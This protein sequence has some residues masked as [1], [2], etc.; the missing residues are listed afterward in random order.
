[1]AKGDLIDRA[2]QVVCPRC[3]AKP[4]KKCMGSI[5]GSTQNPHQERLD[6][7]R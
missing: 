3:G 7:V 5:P 2:L 1:M 6:K 4:K